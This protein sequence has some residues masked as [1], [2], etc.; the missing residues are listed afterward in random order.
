MPSTRMRAHPRHFEACL[1]AAEKAL[2][3]SKREPEVTEKLRALGD[4]AE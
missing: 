2:S 4:P 1:H 3:K